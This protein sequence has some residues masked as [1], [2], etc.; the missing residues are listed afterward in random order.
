MDF[1]Q[2]FAS[3]ALDKGLRQYELA[4][5][6]GLEEY[7]LSRIKR[8]RR[9]ATGLQAMRLEMATEGTLRL[10]DIPMDPDDLKTV[11]AYRDWFCKRRLAKARRHKG[12]AA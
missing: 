10:E 1:D 2:F 5:A 6:A 12:R 8:R 3:L 9:Q 11:L 7:E 4:K